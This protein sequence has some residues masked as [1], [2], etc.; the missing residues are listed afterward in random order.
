MQLQHCINKEVLHAIPKLERYCI[1]LQIQC[2]FN[3]GTFK[4]ESYIM[5]YVYVNGEKN[6]EITTRIYFSQLANGYIGYLF[7]PC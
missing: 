4:N 1:I 5:S 3:T 2:S 6:P 7:Q